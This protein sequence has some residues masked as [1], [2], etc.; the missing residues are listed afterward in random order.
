MIYAAKIVLA[1]GGIL[2]SAASFYLNSSTPVQVGPIPF[3]VGGAMFL[4]ALIFL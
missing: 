4:G 3:F 2:I 1:L